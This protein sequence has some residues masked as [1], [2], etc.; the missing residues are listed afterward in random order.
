MIAT[1]IKALGF[2]IGCSCPMTAERVLVLPDNTQGAIITEL[3]TADA[4]DATNILA[5]LQDLSKIYTI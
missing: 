2:S 4:S 3:V 1:V 5:T